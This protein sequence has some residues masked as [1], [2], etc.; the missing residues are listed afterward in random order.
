MGVWAIIVNCLFP[1]PLVALLL[2]CL[3]LPGKI[4]S[5]IRNF[6]NQLLNKV[7]FSRILGGFSLYQ[8][9]TLLSSMLFVEASWATVRAAHKVDQAET[10]LA[11]E[12]LRCNKWRAE[13]NFWIAMF[14]LVLWLIL[15]RVHKLSKDYE[16]LKAAAREQIAAEHPHNE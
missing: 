5:P 14:S 3:P 7:L 2:L 15:Y 6:V 8:I 1:V 4:A 13:R 12:H 11:E 10:H 9:S 16:A